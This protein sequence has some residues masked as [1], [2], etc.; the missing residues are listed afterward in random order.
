MTIIS[1]LTF[2]VG[3]LA[4]LSACNPKPV[5]ETPV[6]ELDLT[7][8]KA[9]LGYTIGSQFAGQLS[10]SKLLDEIELDALI[11]AFKDAAEGKEPRLTGEQ[12]QQ[13]QI[14]FQQKAQAK[15]DE[16]ANANKAKGDAFLAENAKKEG[17]VITE[18]GLQYEILREGKGDQPTAQSSV[19]VHYAGKLTDGTEFDSSYQRG[20]PTDFPVSG[21][22]PGF[23]EGLQL[24]KAGAKYRFTIP[25]GLAYGFRAPESIGPNQ[26]LIFEVEL[27]EVL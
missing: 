16:L 2:S 3:V 12:M 13:A 1:K 22:I 15:V 7:T 14:S 9:K 17:V 24:M 6:K 27:I 4:L 25:S 18:S 10:G 19:K 23:S 5:A 20:T 11:A 26:A 21:V 8:E